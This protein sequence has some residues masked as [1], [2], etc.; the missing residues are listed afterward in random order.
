VVPAI[1]VEYRL[2]LCQADLHAKAVPHLDE[3]RRGN[4]LL[5]CDLRDTEDLRVAIKSQRGESTSIGG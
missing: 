1:F 2:G 5:D 3:L 4:L